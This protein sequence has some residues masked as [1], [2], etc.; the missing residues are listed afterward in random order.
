MLLIVLIIIV[1]ILCLKKSDCNKNYGE[2]FLK[3]RLNGSCCRPLNEYENMHDIQNQKL[4]TKIGDEHYYLSLGNAQSECDS[5]SSKSAILDKIGKNIKTL[6]FDDK[7]KLYVDNDII[8]GKD[9]NLC[10]ESK[11][12][13]PPNSKFLLAETNDNGIIF[14]IDNKYVAK[15]DN[16]CNGL[17]L[18]SENPLVF[19]TE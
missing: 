8:F 15:C 19:N 11:F 13:N 3:S 12:Y 5:C 1:L 14:K 16:S 18:K 10:A 6:N 17:C 9:N 7:K 2:Y 4:K